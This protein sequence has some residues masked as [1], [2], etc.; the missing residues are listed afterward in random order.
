L[1]LDTVSRKLIRLMTMAGTTSLVRV[2]QGKLSGRPK[3]G[4]PEGNPPITAPPAVAKPVVKLNTAVAT[5]QEMTKL[6]TPNAAAM[7]SIRQ[8]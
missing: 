7:P 5:M 8:A 3:W 1:A 2:A 6:V 4:N